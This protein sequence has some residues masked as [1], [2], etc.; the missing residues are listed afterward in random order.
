MAEDAGVEPALTVLETAVP[1]CTPIL[2]IWSAVLVLP[3]GPPLIRRV[4]Y[5]YSNSGLLV[6]PTG[7][8]PVTFSLPGRRS[9]I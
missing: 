3:Q 7:I 2:Y 1:P 6:E 9:P 4:N 5:C 8:A